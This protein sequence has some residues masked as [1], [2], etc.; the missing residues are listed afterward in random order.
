M[1]EQ[2][3]E[4]LPFRERRASVARASGVPST[5]ARR[6]SDRPAR[7]STLRP[8]CSIGGVAINLPT[9]R[10]AHGEVVDR[11]SRGLGFSLFTLNLDHLARIRTNSRY[12]AAY[13]RAPLVTADGWPVVWLANRRNIR[14]E[15]T[16]GADLVDPVCRSA[17]LHE[18]PVFFL[19]PGRTSQLS[20]L[21]VLAKRHPALKVAGFYAPNISNIPTR[22]EV[23]MVAR[24]L[25]ESGARLCFV[26]LGAPKQELLAD[27]LAPLCARVGFL[28]VGAALDFIS[29]HSRRA[30]L[31]LRRA[32]LEW[33]WRLLGD[34]KRLALRYLSSAYVFLLLV[35]R[36]K[37]EKP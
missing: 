20:A 2:I 28:C 19:G 21:S 24:R 27:A 15:R 37:S 5:Y 18:I 16:C 34:P 13:Q 32:G 31:W 6:A 4:R 30:P 8:G 3:S 14:L 1:A 33:L 22:N 12:R 35:L 9:L 26:C 29:G 17:A 7:S 36:T 10:A 11:V 23:E 25:N